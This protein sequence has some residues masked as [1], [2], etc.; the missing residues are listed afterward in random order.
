MCGFSFEGCCDLWLLNCWRVGLIVV[1]YSCCWDVGSSLSWG[2]AFETSPSV[3]VMFC[4]CGFF[5]IGQFA[6]SK[7]VSFGLVMSN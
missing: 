2:S 3:C 1:I 4:V 6:V 7:N 5:A